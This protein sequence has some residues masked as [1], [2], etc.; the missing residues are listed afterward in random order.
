MSEGPYVATKEI[1]SN[2]YDRMRST[3]PVNI[4]FHP[5]FPESVSILNMG[6]TM[7]GWNLFFYIAGPEVIAGICIAIYEGMRSTI[8]GEIE[9]DNVIWFMLLRSG[10]PMIITI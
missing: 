5:Y 1:T 7:P 10:L 2:V 3:N 9:D 4:K 8:R 6:R